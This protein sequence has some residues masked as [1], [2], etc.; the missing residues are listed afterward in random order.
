MSTRHIYHQ[1]AIPVSDVLNW[2]MSQDETLSSILTG[3]AWHSMKE[4]FV[5][6]LGSQHGRSRYEN[7]R[8]LTKSGDMIKVEIDIVPNAHVERPLPHFD[9][10]VTIYT[11]DL[12]KALNELKTWSRILYE[13]LA[14]LEFSTL[15]TEK[16]N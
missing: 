11:E 5:T 10:L 15:A 14:D 8:K 1:L 6:D 9:F 4:A 3:E 2:L 12:V 7:L 16:G 13:E